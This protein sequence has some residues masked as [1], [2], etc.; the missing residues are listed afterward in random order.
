VGSAA[1]IHFGTHV[2]DITDSTPLLSGVMM[3]I[4]KR[5]W[6]KIQGCIDGFFGVDNDIHDRVKKLGEKVGLARGLYVYHYYRADDPNIGS[7]NENIF[8]RSFT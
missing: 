3:L 7:V 1:K 6:I 8:R 4:Q 2:S 5:T